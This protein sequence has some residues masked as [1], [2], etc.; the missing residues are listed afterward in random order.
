MLTSGFVVRYA[1]EIR[2]KLASVAPVSRDD[3]CPQFGLESTS[4]D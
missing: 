4:R 1:I 2:A 3:N